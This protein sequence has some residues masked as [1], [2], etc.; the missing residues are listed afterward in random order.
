MLM[1]FWAHPE[2]VL[3]ERARAATSGFARMPEPVITRVVR[4]VERDLAS[5]SWDARHGHLRV[6]D[7]YDAGLRL[8][9]SQRS[10]GEIVACPS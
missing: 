7:E 2:R 10:R 4:A 5:G 1:A 8:V 9:V 6:L 3:D